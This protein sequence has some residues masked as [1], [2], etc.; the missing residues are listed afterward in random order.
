MIATD[1]A[2]NLIT[3]EVVQAQEVMV[4]HTMEVQEVDQEIEADTKEQAVQDMVKEV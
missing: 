4:A 1:Q 2:N 3:E